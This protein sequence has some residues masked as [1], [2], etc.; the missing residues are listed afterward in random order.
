MLSLNL[1][2]TIEFGAH[3]SGWKYCMDA[4]KPLHSPTGILVDDFL[5]RTFCWDVTRVFQGEHPE[6]PYREPWVGF[7]HN[8]PDYP[9]WFDFYNSPQAMF[10]RPIFQESMKHCKG[11]IVLSNY[12][13]NWVEER[14][15]VPVVSLKHPTEIP[16]VQWCPYK[17]LNTSIHGQMFINKRSLVQVG[18]W[19]R[20]LYSISRVPCQNWAKLILPGGI[21]NF[22][23]LRNIEERGLT[24][25]YSKMHN[26][27]HTHVVG[28]HLDNDTYDELLSSCVCYLDLYDSSAN[29]AVVECIA[30]NTPLIVNKIPAVVEYLGEDYPLYMESQ[31]HAGWM[32]TQEQLIIDAHKYLKD[33]DKSWLTQAGWR[34]ELVRLL[35]PILC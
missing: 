20:K 31:E 17:F 4:L 1:R 12:L 9:Y 34:N 19:L 15:D 2:R 24:D 28:R 16:D 13:K 5:E 25:H 22:N 18:Y 32:L 14:L 8:P 33:Q 6:V 35:E 10:A 29:N 27:A 7:L 3:R 26:W 23:H 30:R 21:E 11:L